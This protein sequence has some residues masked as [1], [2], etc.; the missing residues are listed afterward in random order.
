MAVTGPDA[1]IVRLL[2]DK[3]AKIDARSPKRQHAA[4]DG[5]AI[6]H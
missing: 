4:D 1:Q 2:L 6:R 3:G 5:G